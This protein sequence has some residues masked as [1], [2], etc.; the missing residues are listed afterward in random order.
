L[1][2]S[3][4]YEAPH[5]AV[6]FNLLSLH[7]SSAPCSETPEVYVAL[8]IVRDKVSQPHKTRGKIR[9]LYILIFIF[10]DSRREGKKKRFWT[11]W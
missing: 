6:F 2:K 10:L 8:L 9:M 7:L 5:C 4:S 1:A 3:T 11:E